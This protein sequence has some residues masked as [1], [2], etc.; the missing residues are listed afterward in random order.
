MVKLKKQVYEID[1][2]GY[3]K[4]IYVVKFNE[5]GNPIEELAENII[6][7]NPPNG[8]YRA[9]WIGRE[10][11]EDMTQEEI[12]ALNNKAIEP[13]TDDFLLDFEF[14]LSMIELGL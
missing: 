5:E 10:W 6:T 7:V 4:E 3:I 11:I 1:D 14:R 13:T 2:N 12:A 9:K 8:F